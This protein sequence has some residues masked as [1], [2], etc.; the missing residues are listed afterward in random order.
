MLILA[1][2]AKIMFQLYKNEVIEKEAVHTYR[3]QFSLK[4][5]FTEVTQQKNIEG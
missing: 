3:Y 2:E 5:L 4:K 1:Y